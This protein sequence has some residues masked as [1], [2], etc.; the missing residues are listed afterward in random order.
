MKPSCID[1][2]VGEDFDGD[3]LSESSETSKSKEQV[4]RENCTICERQETVSCSR[5]GRSFCEIHSS[6]SKKMQVQSPEHYV[7]T[8]SVCAFLV[9]E[10]CW[11]VNDNGNV[12]CL[13]HLENGTG[14]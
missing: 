11:V 8:C 4:E 10:D 12:I 2:R 13:N 1:D 9:C 5:C 6:N 3:E 14:N 7:G